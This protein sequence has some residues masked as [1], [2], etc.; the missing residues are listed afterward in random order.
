MTTKHEPSRAS[1][2]YRAGYLDGHQ[3]AAAAVDAVHA[4]RDALRRQVHTLENRR[5][6]LLAERDALRA[7][8]AKAGV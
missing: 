4:D 5:A 6:E 3:A 1:R 8:L 7:A 2:D